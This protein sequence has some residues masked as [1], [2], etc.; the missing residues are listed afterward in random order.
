MNK[1]PSVYLEDILEAITKI[2]E[3]IG[4][5]GF[6]EFEQNTEKQDAIIRRFEII[7]EASRRLE[8]DFRETYDQ[9][10]WAQMVDFRNVLIHGYDTIELGILWKVIH[11][12]DLQK[13][14]NQIEDLLK[15]LSA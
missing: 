4:K 15:S 6:E 1:K 3:Y 14:Q 5:I 10:S 12:G 7:G 13:A 8:D 9:I 11:D 2:F